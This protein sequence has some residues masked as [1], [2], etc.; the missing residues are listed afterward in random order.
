MPI[1]RTGHWSVAYNCLQ[2]LE[3]NKTPGSIYQM[4]IRSDDAKY[5][6]WILA[7]LTPWSTVPAPKKSGSKIPPLFGTRVAQEGIKANGK[8]CAHVNGAFKNYTQV[9]ELK[10]A[11]LKGETF[12]HERDTLGMKIRQWD[13]NGGNWR[14]QALFGLLVDVMNR[15]GESGLQIDLLFSEWQALI[16]HLEKLD[17]MDAPGE[18]PLING[19]M[20]LSQLNAKGGPWTRTAMDICM[21]WQLRN[22][23]STGPESEKAAI[24]EVRKRSE[25]LKIPVKS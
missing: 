13:S 2:T 11:V 1:P 21:A 14:L 17:V 10:D 15:Q 19:T 9:I 20:L 3:S 24:E 18:K 4:L 6:S 8:I 5:V 23:G 12:I 22:P 7:A 25:E 16:D